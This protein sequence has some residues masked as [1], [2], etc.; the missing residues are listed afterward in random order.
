MIKFFLAG[1]L[2]L[3]ALQVKADNAN[4]FEYFGLSG[5][6]H[7]YDDLN[8]AQDID[9]AALS[10]LTYQ[11]ETEDIG[12]RF[13]IGHH[14]NQ[15]IAVETG[16]TYF[17]EASFTVDGEELDSDGEITTVRL[18]QGEF[19][20]LSGDIRLIGTL[21]L[22]EHFFLKGYVGAV[23]W[24][25]EFSYLSGAVDALSVI[26]KTETGN[27]SL[28]GIGIAYA[29]NDSVAIVL[30]YEETEIMDVSTQGLALSFVVRF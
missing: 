10:T 7:R 20:T 19:N 4:T 22:G 28:M 11:S 9:E 8:F 13:F 25:N 12:W 6:Y 27:S 17:G 30:D 2:T 24:N 15:Y 3:F 16:I 29:F 26:T 5:Q 1:I 21:S 14:F 23:F 18:F